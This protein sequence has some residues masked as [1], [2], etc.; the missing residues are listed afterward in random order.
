MGIKLCILQHP[1]LTVTSEERVLNAILLW[2]S[3]TKEPW[4]WE[5]IDHLL[6]D[7]SP[8][9]IFKERLNSLHALLPHVRFPLLPGSLLKKVQKCSSAFGFPFLKLQKY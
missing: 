5:K 1:D 9:L 4:N 6:L 3:Q 2:C 7:F 8:G